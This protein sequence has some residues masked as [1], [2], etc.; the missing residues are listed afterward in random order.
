MPTPTP[1][2]PM[3]QTKA[4]RHYLAAPM[5]SAIVADLLF[6]EG[7]EKDPAP[8]PAAARR[9]VQLRRAHPELAAAIRQEVAPKRW[10]PPGA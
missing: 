5:S 2:P 4:L 7:W 9:V 3:P 1:L 8:G 6:L 10:L